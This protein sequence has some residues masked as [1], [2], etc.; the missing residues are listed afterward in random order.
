ML[1]FASISYAGWDDE[2]SDY[3]PSEGSDSGSGDSPSSGEPGAPGSDDDEDESV[4][5]SDWCDNYGCTLL[6]LY[7]GISCYYDGRTLDQRKVF[8]DKVN[9]L[10]YIFEENYND[11]IDEHRIY[12]LIPEGY[13]FLHD[14]FVGIEIIEH[15]W[16]DD[17]DPST[18]PW[19]NK[20]STD[21][22]RLYRYE[23]KGIEGDSGYPE[24]GGCRAYGASF[25][26]VNLTSTGESMVGIDQEGIAHTDFSPWSTP[27]DWTW[28]WSDAYTDVVWDESKFDCTQLGGQWLDASVDYEDDNNNQYYC[29]GD[30]YIWVN[31][32]PLTE[33]QSG[34]NYDL[35]DLQN[36]Q[37]GAPDDSSLI[38][39]A[40]DYCLYSS[41]TEDDGA[42]VDVMGYD[43]YYECEQTG[44]SPYDPALDLS[45]DYNNED[46]SDDCH[47]SDGNLLSTCPFL[48]SNTPHDPDT[49]LGKW[50]AQDLSNPYI[51]RIKSTEKAV[52]AFNWTTVNDAGDLVGS[53]GYPVDIG[54]VEITDLD[55]S[56][57]FA[58]SICEQYLG[59]KWTGSH[60]CGNKY[61]YDA[62]TYTTESYSETIPITYNSGLV[63]YEYA[64]LQGVA[65]DDYAKSPPVRYVDSGYDIEL[66]NVNGS[67]FGC[68]IDDFSKTGTDWYS[69]DTLNTL[70]TA[71][72]NAFAC[73]LME[74]TYLCNYNVSDG[75]WEW[76]SVSGGEEGTYVKNT[77]RYSTGESF[78]FSDPPWS[79]SYDQNYACCA[80]NT[81]WDGTQCVDEY[82]DY[83]YD[84]DGDGEDEH[85]ICHNGEWGGEVETKYDWYHNTDAAAI[86]YCIDSFSCVCSSNEDDDTFC[87]PE[88]TYFYAGCTLTEN[89]YKNDH[90]CEA[91]DSDSDG[92]SDTSQWTSRTKFLA[93]QMMSIASS[94]EYII[95][96]DKYNNALNNYINV[97]P[98][99]EDIN[100]FCVLKQGDEITVGVTLNSDDEEEPMAIDE[101]LITDDFS[102]IL[103]QDI[104]CADAI[105]DS[106]GSVSL[107]EPFGN[108]YSCVTD[109]ANTVYY[110]GNLNALIYIKDSY[111]STTLSYPDVSTYQTLFDVYKTQMTA[112]IDGNDITGPSGSTIKNDD[113]NDFA[114]FEYITD[115]SSL[116][117]D[118]SGI[119]G[120]QDV[121]YN[122]NSGNR[123]YMGVVYPS[124]ITL[125]CN[126]IYAP[127]ETSAIVHCSSDEGLVLERST[128]GSEYWTSLTAGIREE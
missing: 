78:A 126:Q 27:G 7:T 15:Y 71:D 83:S 32:K 45:D 6:T 111:S 95:F 38:S 53:N 10:G 82:T 113:T 90:L 122:G 20:A 119:F 91:V 64:C 19:I 59:G 25:F 63:K 40:A 98:I 104:D 66:L 3:T 68:N 2:G 46:Y 39:L 41:Q 57:A 52:P 26:A 101:D 42:P 96:C 85:Y 62:E 99:A 100:S 87:A 118:S 127:Y 115:Y 84:A 92:T 77:L 86:D 88:G 73:S 123:Y 67:W 23:G 21:D 106:V 124:S 18:V 1:I 110:N 35:E 97:E 29:C 36:A 22:I 50:S 51:C 125:D 107:T 61:D 30:D 117:Y 9:Y 79:D 5:L 60:C 76:Y 103:E 44:F 37:S 12:E 121:K 114:G 56:N 65:Y 108:Y 17:P 24:N 49:D 93:F 89:F 94:T 102:N 72:T 47:D 11:P 120:V 34:I 58:S 69:P 74:N 31:N 16:I 75:N 105:T 55:V 8:S 28:K 81:C 13:D 48:L 80:G 70:I 33:D 112:Y 54:G 43:D 116:Y 14:P 4:L 109:D 128:S